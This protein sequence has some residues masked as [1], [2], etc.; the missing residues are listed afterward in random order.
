MKRIALAA[1]VLALATTG[2]FAQGGGLTQD[3][4]TGGKTPS[5]T[6]QAGPSTMP[7]QTKKGAQ[8]VDP[9]TG[10]PVVTPDPAQGGGGPGG[11]PK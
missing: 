9:V 4:G 8:S 7:A 10:K 1:A 11:T 3:G 6:G 2:A 5:T